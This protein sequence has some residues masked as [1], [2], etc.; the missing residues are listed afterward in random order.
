MPRSNADAT[1]GDGERNDDI[2]NERKATMA[3]ASDDDEALA[4]ADSVYSSLI[5]DCNQLG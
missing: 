3:A 4:S 5:V 2:G 1:I